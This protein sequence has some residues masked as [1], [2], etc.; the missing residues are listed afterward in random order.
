MMLVLY[1][2][3]FSEE[4]KKKENIQSSIIHNSQNAKT[5]QCPPTDRMEK[6][7][8]VCLYNGVLVSHKKTQSANTCYNVVNLANLVICEKARHKSVHI[9]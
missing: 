6:Q 8:V 1:L 3:Q 5:A 9:V 7:N 2:K 4:K